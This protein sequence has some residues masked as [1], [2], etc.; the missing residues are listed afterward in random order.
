MN[1]LIQQLEELALSSNI[2]QKH[3]S[4]IFNSFTTPICFGVN[5]SISCLSGFDTV[6]S[7]CASIDKLLKSRI[8]PCVL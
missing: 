8:K 5:H 4:V 3:S 7:E 1:K 2:A 6:H